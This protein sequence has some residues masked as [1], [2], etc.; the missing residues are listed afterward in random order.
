M[1]SVPSNRLNGLVG[2]PMIHYHVWFNLKPEIPEAAG[3]EIVADFLTQLSATR[4]AAGFQLLRNSGRPP[5]SKLPH[6]HALIEFADAAALGA[7][8]K[9]QSER[10]IHSGGHGRIVEVVCD[11]HV[12]IFELLAPRTAGD[13]LGACEI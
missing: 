4:E 1:G 2:I 9:K 3:L 6:Y 8:M 10:G 11:F 12:E 13:V 7:A 5:R